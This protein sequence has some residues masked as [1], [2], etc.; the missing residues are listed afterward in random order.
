MSDDIHTHLGRALSIWNLSSEP[1][2]LEELLEVLR[3]LIAITAEE[4]T[5]KVEL[6]LH[7]KNTIHDI[8]KAEFDTNDECKCIKLLRVQ[9]GL[10]IFLRN[11]LIHSSVDVYMTLECFCFH[12]NRILLYK[13]QNLQLWG[14]KILNSYMELLANL[15]NRDLN[16]E[17]IN[18]Y[19]ETFLTLNATHKA[20]RS[21]EFLR[22][23][24]IFLKNWSAK[25]DFSSHIMAIA[26]TSMLDMLIE[27]INQLQK[28][29]KLSIFD[30]NLIHIMFP[31]ISH[32]SF[33]DFSLNYHKTQ[34]V[35]SFTALIKACQLVLT[36]GFDLSSGINKYLDWTRSMLSLVTE[37]TIRIL[38]SA[39]AI[40]TIEAINTQTTSVLDIMSHVFQ[41]AGCVSVDHK[42]EIVETLGRLLKETHQKCAVKS[43]RNESS[44]RREGV[45]YPNVKSLC[46][47]NIGYLCFKDPRV[48]NKLRE[49][50]ILELILSNCI[51]DDYNP[52]LKEYSI[53]CVKYA[54]ENNQSN[55]EL[56]ARLEAKQVV[57]DSILEQTGYRAVIENGE[58][59][60]QGGE[61]HV[62]KITV[63]TSPL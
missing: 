44:S 60:L 32:D 49:S 63:P 16:F 28:E 2:R 62:S 20:W 1:N 51:I 61:E 55:Q 58:I 43:L 18:D 36:S 10:V 27:R 54:L 34:T 26:D 15:L 50:H 17:G 24:T 30:E 46:M 37:E 39:T 42:D 52:F 47:E 12:W 21:S 22:P 19:T 38:D 29:S 7:D 56:I 13:T 53:V 11:I 45:V 40:G 5:G 4:S 6:S 57:D 59:K 3:S 25:A 8:L 33:V 14:G 9:R 35:E 31:I 41:S 48:Q 23:F